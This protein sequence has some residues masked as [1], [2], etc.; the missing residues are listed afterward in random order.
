VNG[1]FIQK[2]SGGQNFGDE[3]ILDGTPAS[4]PDNGSTFDE[5][6]PSVEALQEF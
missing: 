1:I 6:A 2:T 5:T 3:V 4:R